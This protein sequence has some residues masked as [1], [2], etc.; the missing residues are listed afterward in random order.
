MFIR[1]VKQA[2]I[3]NQGRGLE[4]VEIDVNDAVS[5]NIEGAKEEYDVD[6]SIVDVRVKQSSETQVSLQINFSDTKAIS[7]D[8]AEPDV[9]IVRF[10]DPG[11]FVD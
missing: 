2:K 6:K 3:A 9:L 11:I 4:G 1:S 7:T 8:I 10:K 5:V